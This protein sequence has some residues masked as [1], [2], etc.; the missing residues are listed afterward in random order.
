MAVSPEIVE[1]PSTSSPDSSVREHVLSEMT[2]L[3]T[4]IEN[5]IAS[6]ATG[7]TSLREALQRADHDHVSGFVYVVKIAEA[8]PGV[9]KI[10]ARRVLAD[11]G[12]GERTRS[13]DVPVAQRDSIVA[14][15]S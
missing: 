13:R 1:R 6:V 11:H 8:V 15:L 5:L 12:L 4:A 10:R 7:R 2:T 3:R 9:G 14:A